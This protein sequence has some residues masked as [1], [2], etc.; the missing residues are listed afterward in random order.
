MAANGCHNHKERKMSKTAE[1]TTAKQAI[2]FYLHSLRDA[3]VALGHDDYVIPPE[4]HEQVKC[5]MQAAADADE[6]INTS[7]QEF[8]RGGKWHRA[9][10]IAMRELDKES[11]AMTAASEYPQGLPWGD[12]MHAALLEAIRCA[13]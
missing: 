4:L 6:G 13:A 1:I 10:N 8:E 7:M 5:V 9:T 2:V 3:G 12:K 11:R